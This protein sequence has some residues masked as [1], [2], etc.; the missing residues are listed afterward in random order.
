VVRTAGGRPA[1][2]APVRSTGG[3]LWLT[4]LPSAGKSTL[5]G[6]LAERLGPERAVE[7][8]DGDV[9]RA[10]LSPELGFGKDE[11]DLQVRRV[12][13]LARRLAAHG[14]LV[15]VP[16]IAP[17][18]RA[19]Q[20][21]RAAHHADGVAYLEVHVATSV[22]ACEARDVKG[23]YARARAGEV[24]GLTGIDD[25]YQPPTAPDLRLATEHRG[26]DACV[27][28]LLGLLHGRGLA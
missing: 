7:V 10:E 24:T 3:T 18:A 5:A 26:I 21:V 15:L 8:L 25:P 1:V 13:Y 9:L 22:A 27:D 14:V 11:R 4:G 17:Y 2:P 23:L 28:D 6:R 20:L 19:R 16:A 12:G